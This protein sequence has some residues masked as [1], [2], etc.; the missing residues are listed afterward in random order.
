M[1]IECS[2]PNGEKFEAVGAESH[3]NDMRQSV[4]NS[5]DRMAM[6][7][8]LETWCATVKANKQNAV[9]GEEAEVTDGKP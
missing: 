7:H 9:I 6:Q 4:R 3:G 2:G 5:E 1:K 8:A